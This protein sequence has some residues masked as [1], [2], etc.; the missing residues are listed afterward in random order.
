MARRNGRPRPAPDRQ[1]LAERPGD[2]RQQKAGAPGEQ[3]RPRRQ[4][5]CAMR[6]AG[7]QRQQQANQRRQQ[8]RGNA[9][10]Q[11]GP[12]SET[13]G[14]L[15][16]QAEC[17]DQQQGRAWCRKRPDDRGAGGG[18]QRPAGHQPEATAQPAGGFGVRLAERCRQQDRQGAE[19]R[20]ADQP[21]RIEMQMEKAQR[22]PVRRQSRNQ[23][24]GDQGQHQAAERS[25]VPAPAGVRRSQSG[26]RPAGDPVEQNGRQ[27]E[28]DRSR[29]MQQ[30]V[31][32]PALHGGDRH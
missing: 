26:T 19:R 20:Q 1:Q 9:V 22:L 10:G 13:P 30:P 27:N 14:P 12:E 25:A 4:Q 16:D 8:R 17:G 7:R 6:H 23:Q 24:H 3:R 29:R 32:Q 5:P 15:A 2:Q 28:V 21:E 31:W 18:H 11:H